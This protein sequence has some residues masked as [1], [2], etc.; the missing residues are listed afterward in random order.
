M[1]TEERLTALEN[2]ILALKR[3]ALIPRDVETAFNERLRVDKKLEATI[4][5]TGSPSAA[6]TYNAFPV[7]NVPV[8]P[9]Q[10]LVVIYNGVT[11]ELLC[12]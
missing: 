5:G 8:Q 2:E 10:T 3:S 11:Y 9:S 4:T 6:T 12:K 1:T 7:S